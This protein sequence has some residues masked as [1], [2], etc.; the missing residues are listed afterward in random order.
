MTAD[1]SGMKTWIND[2][3]LDQETL[4]TLAQTLLDH[5][6]RL[7]VLDHFFQVPI[8]NRIEAYAK[9]EAQYQ[10]IYGLYSSNQPVEKTRWDAANEEDR[11]FSYSESVGVN[12]SGQSSPNAKIFSFLLLC[13]E[14]G[15]FH[16]LF[17]TLAGQ[18][19][20]EIEKPRIHAHNHLD[21]LKIHSDRA[22]GRTLCCVFYPGSQWSE[23]DGG[24]LALYHPDGAQTR[25]DALFNRLLVFDPK[26]LTRHKVLPH[27]ETAKH[28][29]RYSMVFWFNQP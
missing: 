20:G 13:L 29:T 26:A 8:L 4:A 19:L 11:F 21:F 3:Y 5:P 2:H 9:E 28:K 14:R 15:V 22:D 24:A 18:P 6:A 7:L 17:Q 25:V 27:T 1:F 10:Q 23:Q 12:S 16:P